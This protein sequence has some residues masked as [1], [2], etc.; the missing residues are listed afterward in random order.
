MNNIDIRSLGGAM[1]AGTSSWVWDTD[2]YGQVGTQRAQPE[3]LYTG[4]ILHWEYFQR[5]PAW[6]VSIH[7]GL[8]V[9]VLPKRNT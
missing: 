8:N 5:I 3:A 7:M 2:D 9:P 1:Q 6:T 4:G